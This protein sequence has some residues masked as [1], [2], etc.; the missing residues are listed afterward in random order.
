MPTL[1]HTHEHEEHL[2]LGHCDFIS[3]ALSWC[4]GKA[5]HDG[6]HWAHAQLPLYRTKRII[7]RNTP[8]KAGRP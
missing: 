2:S 5:G 6:E 3:P 7:I 1:P 8:Q 4:D